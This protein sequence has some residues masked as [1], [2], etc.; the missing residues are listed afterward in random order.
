VEEDMI[1][2]L[3]NGEI[4]GAGLDVVENEPLSA[5]SPL[6]EMHNVIITAHYSGRSAHYHARALEIFIDNLNRRKYGEPMRNVVD[7]YLAY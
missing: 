4:A 2:A 1:A 3:Q 7:K 6:W 5:G